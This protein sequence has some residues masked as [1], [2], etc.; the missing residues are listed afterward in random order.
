MRKRRRLDFQSTRGDTTTPN[1]LYISKMALEV[2]TTTGFHVETALF[3]NK[4]KNS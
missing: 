3:I 1:A 2:T 4:M